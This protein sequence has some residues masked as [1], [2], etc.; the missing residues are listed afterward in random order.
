M[1]LIK[2]LTQFL[3][4][5]TNNVIKIT[6]V[7]GENS[8]FLIVENHQDHKKKLL[9]INVKN[10]LNIQNFDNLE[11]FLFSLNNTNLDIF[12]S[13]NRTQFRYRGK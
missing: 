5:S 12:V 4:L 7:K 1:N 11:M 8:Q 3:F 2:I 9:S 6:G 10:P 13:G